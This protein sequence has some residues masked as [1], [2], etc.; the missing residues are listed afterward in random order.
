MSGLALHT[1]TASSGTLKKRKRI[2]RGNSST[3][4]YSGRGIKGQKARSGGKHKLKARALKK[5]LMQLPK[6]HGMTPK[7]NNIAICNLSK[8]EAAFSNG[9]SVSPKTLSSKGIISRTASTIKILANGELTKKL[10]F[11]GCVMSESARKKI[12]LAGGT[13]RIVF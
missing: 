2:G 3:G 11:S 10:Q 4:T 8:I 6:I 13:V 12:E 9:E 1:L 5:R 7:K